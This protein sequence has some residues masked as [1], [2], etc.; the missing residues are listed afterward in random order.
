[1]AARHV[2]RTIDVVLP[3]DNTR[4]QD[5]A[6]QGQPLVMFAPSSS[7]AT[8]IE[9]LAER[10]TDRT[11]NRPVAS[12]PSRLSLILAGLTNWSIQR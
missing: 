2:N 11:P 4:C 8:G 12:R 7:F 3:R 5:A 6:E 9:R 1:L 10:F